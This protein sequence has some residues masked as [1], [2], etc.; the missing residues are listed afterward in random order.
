MKNNNNFK[1]VSGLIAG[2]LIGGATI[3][4]ANQAIQ[5][6]QN[7]E[8]K[9]S[10]NGQV[11]TFKDE[12]TGE[13]QY[14]ITYHDRTY[15]PLRNV[16]RLSGL[17]V[18][19]DENTNTAILNNDV[20]SND[21]FNKNIT[22]YGEDLSSVAYIASDNKFEDSLTSS[23]YFHNTLITPFEMNKEGTKVMNLIVDK[24]PNNSN[25][26][27]ANVEGIS[28]NVKSFIGIYYGHYLASCFLNTENFIGE[29]IWNLNEMLVL[30]ED[31]N[32]YVRTDT[33]F[34][35]GIATL[36]FEKCDSDKK[37]KHIATKYASSDGKPFFIAEV[38][39]EEHT[40][41]IDT[42][43]KRIDINYLP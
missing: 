24:F 19:Y 42:K 4:Y 17:D 40:A 16:A 39:G 8:I 36:H 7:T 1:L 26:E 20:F 9:V 43:W 10:L 6:L 30:T 3:V 13:V 5:A 31:G 38:E 21:C 27:Y 25:Y 18:D 37:V 15:L 34:D 28:G 12:T 23:H 41:E 2:M 22:S 11:Q 14:P 29:S 35:L 32:V 33:T